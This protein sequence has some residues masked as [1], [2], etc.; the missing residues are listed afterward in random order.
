MN[1][2]SPWICHIC[3]HKSVNSEPV[4]CSVCYKITC[5]MHLVHKTVL[6]RETGLYELQPVCVDCQIKANL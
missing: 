1:E 2:K 4:A 5:A 3:D 6:S